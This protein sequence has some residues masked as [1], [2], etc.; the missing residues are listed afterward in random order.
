MGVELTEKYKKN[1]MPRGSRGSPRSSPFGAK[2][3]SSN[4]AAA[5]KPPQQ[6]TSN[7]T[8]G[9]GF[10]ASMARGAA[11]GVGAGAASAAVH[12]MMGGTSRYDSNQEQQ[13]AQQQ[14]AQ[15]AQQNPC[16]D[17]LSKFLV[18]AQAQNYHLSLC[19]PFNDFYMQCK[20]NNGLP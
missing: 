5:P 10:G 13:P 9:S 19:T 12:G 1:I 2:R 18:C 3:H 16:A 8:Q 6:P 20:R 15:Q 7:S 17:E 14:A 4:S 11:F